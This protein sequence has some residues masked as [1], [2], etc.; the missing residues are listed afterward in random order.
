MADCKRLAVLLFCVNFVYGV[1]IY[2][3]EV[4]YAYVSIEDSGK[5]MIGDTDP[6][7]WVAS[8]EFSNKVNETG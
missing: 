1:E 3:G 6:G 8:A 4:K 7:N 5:Y 2:V